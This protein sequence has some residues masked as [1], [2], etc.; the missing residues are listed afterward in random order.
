MKEGPRCYRRQNAPA[1]PSAR[2]S[3]RTA[4]LK[5]SENYR[6]DF[7]FQKLIRLCEEPNS[8]KLLRYR[9]AHARGARPCATAVWSYDIHPSRLQ[10][11][12][13]EQ[14][15]QRNNA[16]PSIQNASRK[17]SDDHLHRHIRKSETLPSAQQVCVDNRLIC[18][19]LKS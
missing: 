8:G 5:N 16:A 3:S 15:L 13:R 1:Q 2:H 12:W 6:P 7:D 4:E 17:V 14:V 10:L 11:R 9:D 18:C 19:S